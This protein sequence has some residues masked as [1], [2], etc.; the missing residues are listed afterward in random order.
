MQPV[1]EITQ[2]EQNQILAGAVKELI[3]PILM[4]SRPGHCLRI[5][6]LS[7]PVMRQVCDELNKNGLDTDIVYILNPRQKAEFPWQITSTR[8]IELR[9]E[10]KRSLLAFIPP[11][12]K[13]AAEDSFDVST[14]KEIA[15]DS[16]PEN[17]LKNLRQQLP[18]EL[19]AMID[20]VV[21]Y[22]G[23]ECNIEA[24]DLIRYYL[25]ILKNMAQPECAGGAIYHLSLVPDFLLYQSPTLIEVRLARNLDSWH[26]LQDGDVSLLSRIHNLRLKPNSLQSDLYKYLNAKRVPDIRGWGSELA[27]DPALHYLCFDQW[28]FEGEQN[29]TK[30]L[31]FV[32]E[33]GL[34]A[35]DENQPIGP[36]N[37]PYLDVNKAP[38]IKVS[39][40]TNPKPSLVPGIKYLRI[41]IIGTDG[42]LV[43]WESKNIPAISSS[44]KI[45]VKDFRD[46]V[47]DGLYYFRVRAYSESGE[48]L[49]Y[50]D[51]EENSRVLRDPFNVNSKHINT[52]EDVWFWK[53]PN[54]E[55]PPVEA[56]RNIAVNS[57]LDA[58]LQV[59]F[60]AMDRGAD[61]FD[62]SLTPLPEKT[63]WFASKGK[64]AEATF[65]IVYDAQMKYTLSISSLLRQI[66]SDTLSKPENLGRWR[67]SFSDGKTYQTVEPTERQ[68]H[69]HSQIPTAFLQA[70][71]NLFTAIQN[72]DQKL[73]VETV[74]LTLYSDLIL[75]YANAYN[76]WIESV[77]IDYEQTL[78]T[79]GDDG[80]RRTEAVLLD[81]DTVQVEIPNDTPINDRVYLMIPTHPLRLLWHLQRSILAK[82]WLEQAMHTDQ[83][84]NALPSSL[85]EFL[86][87][88]LAPMTLPPFLKPAHESFPYGAS[89]FYIEQ[90]PLT[91]FW[92]LYT[93]EEIKDRRALFA[94]VKRILAITR[95]NT[96][97]GAV[98][99]VN[100]ETLAQKFRRYLI[101]HPYV[102][103]LKINA[104]N[105]GD[106]TLLVD[107]ILKIEKDRLKV[108][109][110]GL[111]YEIH[112][113]TQ[114]SLLNDTG[115]AIEDLVNPERQVSP[116][117][118]AFSNPSQNHLF[119]KLRFYRNHVDE[120]LENHENYQAH[121]SI[122]HDVFPVDIDVNTILEGRS[123]F[124]HGLIQDQV[125]VFG[126]EAQAEYA[127]QRQLHPTDCPGLSQN[128]PISKL[129][130]NILD[131]LAMVQASVAVGKPAP[132]ARPTL[133]LR[134]QIKHKNLL[135]LV[136]KTTDWVF[137]IDRNLGLEYFDS[138]PT[139]GG[140]IYLLDFVPEFANIDTDRLFLTTQV[141]EEITGLIQ[142]I[143][144][145]RGLDRG[146]GMEIYILN[147]LRSLSGRLA[148][149]L[150]SSPTD[151]SGVLGLALARL[152]LEQFG[153][154]EDCILIPVDSHID[155]FT[156]SDKDNLLE[157][158]ISFKRGDLLL[159]GCD[160]E[161]RSLSFNI[162]EVKLRSDLGDINAYLSLRQGIEDQLNNTEIE[163][164]K[165]FDPSIQYID[166]IDRQV[167]TKE[168]ISL[169]SFYL[170]RSQRYGLVSKEAGSLFAKF[171]QTLDEGYK[172]TTSGVGLVF[173]FGSEDLAVDEEHAGLIFYR[174]GKGYVQRLADAGLRQDTMLQET[175]QPTAAI[176]EALQIAEKH[177]EILRSSEIRKDVQFEQVR[178][179][180]RKSTEP[181]KIDSQVQ[182]PSQDSPSIKERERKSFEDKPIPTPEKLIPAPL[183][184]EVLPSSA[185]SDSTQRPAVSQ[186]SEIPQPVIETST[187]VDEE[188]NYDV[189]IGDSVPSRQFGLIGKAGGKLLALDLNGTNTISL[190]GV[191]GGGKSYTVGTIIEIATQSLPG[192]NHL[193]GPLATV[194]FH[195][196]ENQDYPP[197]FVSMVQANDKEDEIK[198]LA[199]EY[200]GKPIGLK[201]VLIL[202]SKDK[203]SERQAEF[204]GMHVEPIS[205]SSRELSF[206]DW[207]FL[208]GVGGN[209]MYMKQINMI[210]RQLR[211]GMTLETLREEIENSELSDQQKNIANLRLDFAAQFI[212]DERFLAET[213]KP[214]RLIIVDLRDEFI[215]KDEALGLFVV[216]L[217]IF[218]NA[219]HDEGYN[220]LIV[221]DEAHKYMDNPDLTSH[222]VDVIRQMRHQ[223]V[224]VLIASQ[225]PP[226]LPSAIIELSS[227]V[228]LHRFNSPQWLRHIQKSITALSDLT[229]QQMSSLAPGEAFLWSTKS[230]ERIFTQKAVKVRFRPRVTRHGGGTKTAV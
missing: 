119:P 152:F 202:T 208:M 22:L 67:V 24:N 108:K 125:T 36:N 143:L 163:L 65:Q 43:A 206:K 130:A 175:Q 113:F 84:K 180:F 140:A 170:Q 92:S 59:R 220:K 111:S 21:S 151:V 44:K 154:L 185:S 87:R 144:V 25:T 66:E 127:W 79:T 19:G 17:I 74:D 93:P 203:L 204:P 76:A 165:R 31:I 6:S 13:A 215:D 29:N 14:F 181:K 169:L 26:V 182:V 85:R 191:Q 184:P 229:P 96:D 139:Q 53:D 91:P 135:N 8:L 104:F 4:S 55:P 137:V 86:R 227:V 12:L 81:I 10:E 155:L 11:G 179:A 217:N 213:L 40:I 223:G 116:E 131:Q 78:I 80:R 186:A 162:I 199:Q 18:T 157:D 45:N 69:N 75:A 141:T 105:A 9:N 149:K 207:R 3:T 195:Y 221:F 23:K 168:L 77:N 28:P 1:F 35:H 159:V 120:F 63:G 214:G 228:V 7:E 218:A 46:I 201:D 33:L 107:A 177:Q 5:S 132:D 216:M 48:L 147:L 158:E 109:L 128:D 225:D 194:I 219:G 110:P 16:I 226:S 89:R 173:D 52:S 148:L 153:L 133:H 39:W 164:R 189:L 49:N 97:A 126:S 83:P 183:D 106:A 224:S 161:N 136:H 176:S 57:F 121:I 118:D 145:E 197:E 15:L 192:T 88:G 100:S 198:I 205:F 72:R 56:A 102:Q 134:L 172:I 70:R 95:S 51:P 50:E 58:Q 103:T 160:P 150:L 61:P 167:K 209:Q 99:G 196:H 62:S 73:L 37:P 60:A 193:P 188:P 114:G 30:I 27:N 178:T 142:P 171:I 47:E 34:K 156:Q 174:V 166:R 90:G 210:M 20:R 54:G 101:Q 222:I 71:T 32:E 187:L 98:G 117:A 38:S 124:L 123:S 211:Q 68:F 64:S 2:A 41:E 122:L 129:L 212:D 190:F 200:G 42:D 146:E 94:R 112:L 230:T 82:T 115:E 138:G